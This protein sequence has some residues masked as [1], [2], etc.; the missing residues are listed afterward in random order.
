M[1]WELTQDF[2]GLFYPLSENEIHIRAQNSGRIAHKIR[3]CFQEY[4]RIDD[5]DAVVSFESFTVLKF[6]DAI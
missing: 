5:V 6:N 1:S 2:S 3:Q 4:L